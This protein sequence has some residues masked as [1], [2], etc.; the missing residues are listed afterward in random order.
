LGERCHVRLTLSRHNSAAG[1]HQQLSIECRPAF[2][3]HPPEEARQVLNADFRDTMVALAKAHNESAVCAGLVDGQFLLALPMRRNLF[4]P[5][6]I[7]RSVYGCEADVRDLLGQI[8]IVH[9]VIDFLKGDRHE[10]LT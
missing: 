1:E 2:G 9:R 3:P 10:R 4:E 6:S 8:T 5:G 7:L